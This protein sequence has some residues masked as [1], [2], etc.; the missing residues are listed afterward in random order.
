MVPEAGPWSPQECDRSGD[1]R[2]EGRELEEFCRRLLRRPELEELFGHYSGEDCV[3]SAEELREFLR[4][5]GEEATLRQARAI[6][7]AHELNEKG[8]DGDVPRRGQQAWRVGW[9]WSTRGGSSWGGRGGVPQVSTRLSR[10]GV[11]GSVSLWALWWHWV[12]VRQHR[13]HK[14]GGGHQRDLHVLRVL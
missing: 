7:H 10:A 14:G 8:R 11:R 3:L 1:E 13:G 5:Q 2:L 6:I 4:D 12:A 9:V